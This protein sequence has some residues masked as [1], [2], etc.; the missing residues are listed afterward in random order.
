[1]SIFSYTKVYFV[2]LFNTTSRTKS[3]KSHDR[4]FLK[5]LKNSPILTSLVP[6]NFLPLLCLV[7]HHLNTWVILVLYLHKHSVL[8]QMLHMPFMQFQ[9]ISYAIKSGSWLQQ[10]S[11][12]TQV[13]SVDNTTTIVL[14]LEMRVRE[15]HEDLL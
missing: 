2:F 15:T 4:S 13:S 11:I 8:S 6:L 10:V 1:M 3:N 5:S 9:Y 12:L 14:S 7:N